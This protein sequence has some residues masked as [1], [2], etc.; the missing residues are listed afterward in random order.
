MSSTIFIAQSQLSNYEFTEK[1]PLKVAWNL[2]F[3]VF[4]KNTENINTKI[5]GMF[6]TCFTF[7]F[8]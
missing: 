4:S 3:L 6:W 8:S 1:L 7:G 5:A 2:S